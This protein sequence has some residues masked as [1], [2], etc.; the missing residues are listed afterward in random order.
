[1]RGLPPGSKLGRYII[2]GELGRGG[3]GVVYSARDLA[4]GRKVALKVLAPDL[5]GDP[6][7]VVR[8]K[9]ESRLAAAVEHPNVVPIYETGE[10]DGSLFIAMRFVPG[11]DLRALVDAAGP[12][13]PELALHFLQQIAA[14]LDAVHAGRLIHGDIKPA[15]VLV[16]EPDGQAYLTDFGL[17]REAASGTTAMTRGEVVI[18]TLDYMAPERFRGEGVDER[19]DIYS[20]AALLYQLV[21]GEAPFADRRTNEA[22]MYAHVNTPPPRVGPSVPSALNA[23]IRRGMS[24][25]PRKRFQ[26][27]GDLARAATAAIGHKNVRGR[28]RSRGRAE[29]ATGALTVRLPAISFGWLSTRSLVAAACL[30]AALIVA[31]VFLIAANSGGG[32][33]TPAVADLT[34]V[35]GSIPVLPGHPR[36]KTKPQAR[37]KPTRCAPTFIAGEQLVIKREKGT[38]DCDRASD[39]WAE[40]G[41]RAPTE[42]QG[43]GGF[44]VFSGWECIVAKP[45][46][47]RRLG[48]CSKPGSGARFSVAAAGCPGNVIG[49]S[50]GQANVIEV[51]DVGCD[52]AKRVLLSYLER[53]G[54]S[55]F[56]CEGGGGTI[57]SC[58]RGPQSFQ[59]VSD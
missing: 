28:H 30:A 32:S 19:G 50:G 2:E 11:T 53:R 41:R 48:S 51:L 35:P 14:G 43:S 47:P 38:V 17:A 7:F 57:G 8:F 36:K 26:S 25:D 58:A 29:A 56:R 6:L 54:T 52:V 15:N 46:D 18:G 59:F 4:L 49:R 37:P 55:G 45:P 9:E 3:M 44:L 10:D 21:A 42:G 31:D 12:V 20:L 33:T 16:T 5:A 1:M 40:Y 39:V 24:K 23:V 22:K 34:A 13:A 27:A